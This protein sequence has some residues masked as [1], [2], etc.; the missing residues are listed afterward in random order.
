MGCLDRGS[1]R[2]ITRAQRDSRVGHLHGLWYEPRTWKQL[3]GDGRIYGIAGYSPVSAV[4][5]A[6]NAKRFSD[7]CLDAEDGNA[8]PLGSS[9][10]VDHARRTGS[11]ELRGLA[12]CTRFVLVCF[13]LGLGVPPG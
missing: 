10:R 8:F 7:V 11:R 1:R 9:L 13:F 2:G 5:G 6:G 12:V 3:S 4:A